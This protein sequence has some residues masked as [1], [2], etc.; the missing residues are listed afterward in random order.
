MLQ[1]I[2]FH[3]NQ[4][5]DCFAL[6]QQ[7]TSRFNV[8]R[9]LAGIHLR[10]V[11]TEKKKVPQ[12]KF[13]FE[14]RQLSLFVLAHQSALTPL[15]PHHHTPVVSK[16]FQPFRVISLLE[17]YGDKKIFNERESNSISQRRGTEE[18][19]RESQLPASKEKW[20]PRIKAAHPKISSPP[21]K[22]RGA[23]RLNTK[24]SCC[25]TQKLI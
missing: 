5:R 15:L 21:P 19:G 2:C 1:R 25:T 18:E 11:K 6:H 13:H 17:K 9:Q 3:G 7:A 16:N 8:K 12:N 14:K 24:S 20:K 10:V 4:E 23:Y 22:K